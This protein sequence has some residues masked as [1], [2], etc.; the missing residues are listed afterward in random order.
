MLNLLINS[1]PDSV[2][3]NNKEYKIYTDFREFIEADL[4]AE[5]GENEKL[6]DFVL[7]LFIDIPEPEYIAEAI[8]AIYRFM[9]FNQLDGVKKKA[10]GG[11]P[12][13]FSFNDDMCYIVSD[14]RRYYGIDLI[15]IKYLHWYEFM[16]LLTGLPNDSGLKER[17]YYRSI[18]LSEIK[19]KEERKRIRK[20]QNSLRI[21]KKSSSWLSES[22]IANAFG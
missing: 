18:N 8:Q 5:N 13:V 2:I 17:I 19:D 6:L 9:N 10:G 22:E 12:S 4:Y 11:Q 20:I 7:S 16:T 14:F 21:K 1:M 3:I 15:N